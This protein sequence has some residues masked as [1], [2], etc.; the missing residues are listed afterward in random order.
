MS[1]IKW[2]SDGQ[3]AFEKMLLAVPE[4][5]RQSVKPQLLAMLAQRAGSE[6]VGRDV[7]FAFVTQDLPEPQRTVLS[8]ALGIKASSAE[9]A[10]TLMAKVEWKVSGEVRKPADLEPLKK[11]GLALLVPDSVRV[12]VGG[13][14][15]GLAAGS[16]SVLEALKK[17]LARAS[18]KADVVFVGSNGMSYAEPIVDVICPGKPR[19]TYGNV[20]AARVRDIAQAVAEGTVVADLVLGA[21]RSED[22]QGMST[23]LQYATSE[24]TGD[25]ARCPSTCDLPFFKNQ[26]RLL[27][28]NAGT[29]SPERIEEYIAVGGY[30]VIAK[31]LTSMK[32]SEVMSQVKD[33]ML[34]GRGGAG[35]WAGTKW[36]A[37]ADAAGDKKYVVCNGSEGDP[38][39]GMHKS[40]FESDPHAVIEGMMLAGYAI[41]ADE[42]YLY[43]SDRYLLA[44]ERAEAAVRQACELGLLGDKI[45]GTGFSFRITIKRGGGAYVC[46][47]ETALLSSLEGMFGE[48]RLRPPLPVEKGL[49]GK[50]TIVNNLETLAN[51]PLIVQK[52]G[53]WFAEIGTKTSKGT[54]IVALVGN[55]AKPC[56]VEVPLGT[57]V[58]DI[59]EGFGGGTDTG[60]PIKAFQTGGPSGGLLPAS[61]LDIAFDYDALAE[62]GSLLGSGGLL[63]MDEKIDLFDMARFFGDF[64]LDESCGKCTVCSN[65]MPQLHKIV[66]QFADGR[67]T[68]AHIAQVE[69]LGEAM[70]DCCFCALGKSGAATM[71]S[72][73]RHFPEEVEK[74][75]LHT[76]N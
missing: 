73:V 21:R 29:I 12:T 6:P 67:G 50:P 13:A 49:Y 61:L 31:A 45:F 76:L 51:I 56:W 54:K 16:A 62:Q 43:L 18:I 39:I 57:K 74:R 59:V 3:E 15:C 19:V 8:A 68:D 11:R 63:V 46:G 26:L 58:R 75:K 60:R 53:R 17:E 1:E 41:G 7:I 33:S 48:P 66:L 2:L 69:R 9:E 70:A 32:P 37:C 55:V 40:F 20:T 22:L 25:F 42:G 64:F 10:P 14:T 34:R 44:I 24:A 36:Q 65:G 4:S 71:L 23:P 72:L 35:F 38:E 52:G 30:S 5:M 28:R 47:E 27:T